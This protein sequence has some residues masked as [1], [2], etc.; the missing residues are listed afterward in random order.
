DNWNGGT[1]LWTIYIELPTEDYAH[2]RTKREHLEKQISARVKTV[3]ESETQDWYAVSIVPSRNV[4]KN[5]RAEVPDL[6]RQV[7]KNIVDG[8]RLEGVR[9]QGQLDDVEFLDRIYELDA[10]PS[11]DTR[12]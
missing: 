7:R 1:E 8:L 11:N 10:L 4:P 5:W 3:I 12:F 2:L 9:W 6:G